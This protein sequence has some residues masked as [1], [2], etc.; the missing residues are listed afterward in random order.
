[1]GVTGDKSTRG[2]PDGGRSG[3]IN[4]L[5]TNIGRGHPFYLDGI[6]ECLPPGRVGDVTDV[7]GE[8]AGLARGLWAG[9]R[10]IYRSV[11]G[12]G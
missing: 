1:M 6:I 11:G 12:G 3:R 9:A 4:F 2:R 7:F 10:I 5:Y 8:T